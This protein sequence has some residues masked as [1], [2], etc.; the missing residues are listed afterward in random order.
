[1]H[2]YCAVDIV[3]DDL[4]TEEIDGNLPVFFKQVVSEETYSVVGK[5]NALAW[6]H[7]NLWFYYL[8]AVNFDV[9]DL[10]DL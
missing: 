10:D 6:L 1:M 9:T 4:I 5:E 2:C 8:N 7:Y 3:H